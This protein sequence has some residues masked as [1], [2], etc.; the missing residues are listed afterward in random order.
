[1]ASSVKKVG[2]DTIEQIIHIANIS[3]KETYKNILPEQQLQYML[4]LFYSRE[5]LQKQIEEYKHQFIVLVDDETIAGFASYSVKAIDDSTTYKLH[6]IY[7]DPEQQRKGIGKK[8]LDF[9]ITDVTS[10]GAEYLE[11]NVNRSNKAIHFYQKLGFIIISE[12]DI[13]IGNNYFMNDYVMRKAL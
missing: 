2:V 12:A 8:L 3:W 6:K 1:M 13:D 7:I 11:L 10:K 5:A 4:Q 9:I